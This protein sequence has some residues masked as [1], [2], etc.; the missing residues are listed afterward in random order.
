V[1]EEVDYKT[2]W[3]DHTT[4][5]I[6]DSFQ[7]QSHAVLALETFREPDKSEAEQR[8]QA[9]RVRVF[10][11]R[12]RRLSYGVYFPRS[13]VHEWKVRICSAIEA[14]RL[15]K[16]NNPPTWP[17]LEACRICPAAALCPV[18]DEPIAELAADPAGFI[19]KLVAVEGRAEAMRKLAAEYVDA[20]KRDIH[21]DGVYFGRNKP[22]SER[23]AQATIYTLKEKS[24]GSSDGG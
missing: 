3:K 12:A 6:R 10:D 20:H 9:L 1:L 7:F 13:R 19:R 11:T 16:L 17:T 18:A 8:I 14:R 15:V 22:K 2:G 4:E 21:S 24:N 5:D 23:K